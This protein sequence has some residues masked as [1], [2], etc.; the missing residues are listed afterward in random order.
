M[1]EF[2]RMVQ[3]SLAGIMKYAETRT[4]AAVH[5]VHP[6]RTSR[7][8]CGGAVHRVLPDSVPLNSA[9]ICPRCIQFQESKR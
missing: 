7:T 4:G 3:Q 8:R 2:E 9:C 1:T 5:I 6:R